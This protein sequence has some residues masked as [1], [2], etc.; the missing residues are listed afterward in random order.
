MRLPRK[1]AR[2]SKPDYPELLTKQVC[3]VSLPP[4][5]REL[6]FAAESVGGVGK[7]IRSRLAESG[8]RDWRFDLAWP[9]QLLAV[10]VDGGGFVNGGH[11][12]GAHMESDCAK[13][14]TAVS[15]GWRV[16]R[17]TPR[18]VKNGE[19]LRWVESALKVAA[20]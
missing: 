13:I 15:M 14:S 6:R 5:V 2:A 9:A 18:Q 3:M 17:V 11:S 16:M 1:P 8:L 4:P 19:A 7:G 12:R 10:E 20:A